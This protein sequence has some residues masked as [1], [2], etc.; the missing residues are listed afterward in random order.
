[1]AGK[2]KMASC[3]IECGHQNTR[4]FHFLFHVLAIDTLYIVGRQTFLR[5]AKGVYQQNSKLVCL[6]PKM[7]NKGIPVDFPPVYGK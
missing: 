1:M 2:N 3:G 6:N 7:P 4:S 5:F